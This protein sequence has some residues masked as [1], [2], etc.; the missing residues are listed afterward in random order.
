MNKGNLPIEIYWVFAGN[1]KTERI[2]TTDDGIAITRSGNRLSMLNIESVKRRNSGAYTCVTKNSAGQT[3]F[4]TNLTIKGEN[5][6]NNLS[7]FTI[8]F[9]PN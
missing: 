4:T 3:N 1:D 7:N 5:F 6:I 2:L 8:I 9:D